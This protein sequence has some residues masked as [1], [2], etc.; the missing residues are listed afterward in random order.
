MN[1]KNI[2]WDITEEDKEKFITK[3]TDELLFLRTKLGLS[4]DELSNLLGVSRQ[5]YSTIETKRRTMSWGTYLSLVL[6]FDNHEQTRYIIHENG[7]FPDLLFDTKDESNNKSRIN[8]LSELLIEEIKDKLD[9]RALHAIETVVMLE[10]ARCNNMS[11]DAVIKAFDGKRF[12]A[13]S[14]KDI[15]ITNAINAIKSRTESKSWT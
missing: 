12:L 9:D 6:I 3:L 10:Y 5:T 7:I 2:F 13:V 15:E 1:K 4:Q 8:D 11:G 14:Q